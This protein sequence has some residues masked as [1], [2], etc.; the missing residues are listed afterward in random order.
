VNDWG[1]LSDDELYGRLTAPG[2]EP[3]RWPGEDVQKR[4]TGRFGPGLVVLTRKFTAVLA[5][6]GAVRP[7]WR[8]LD[9]GAGFGRIAA[10][11]LAEG[12]PEQLD[13]ADAWDRSL[14]LLR[15][16]GFRNRIR[17]TSDLLREGELPLDEYDLIY[18]FSVFTHLA[19]DAFWHN[20]AA[21]RRSLRPGGRLYFT[22]RHEDFLGNAALPQE[23]RDALR[24]SLGGRGFGFAVSQRGAPTENIYG[25]SLIEEGL[26]RRECERRFGGLRALGPP[27]HPFQHLY[28]VDRPPGA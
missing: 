16:G 12:G 15:A 20:L 7:G 11:M 10:V 6:D 22:V 28:V 23:V 13:L 27:P 9:Y 17:K 21:L 18:S 26:L 4:Y 19:E 8:G 3:P 5:A 2:G 24:A 1:S 25:D 14:D